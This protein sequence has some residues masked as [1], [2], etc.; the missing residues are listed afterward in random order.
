MQDPTKISPTANT[1]ADVRHADTARTRHAMPEMVGGQRVTGRASKRMFAMHDADGK[2]VP[3]LNVAR[4]VGNSAEGTVFLKK[5]ELHAGRA[6]SLKKLG[7]ANRI[8]RNEAGAK[9]MTK[10]VERPHVHPRHKRVIAEG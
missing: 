9:F 6:S 10:L 8:A 4:V 2:F 3:E 5:R 1:M 7:R